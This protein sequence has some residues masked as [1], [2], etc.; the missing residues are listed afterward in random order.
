[1]FFSIKKRLREEDINELITSSTKSLVNI[2]NSINK[3]PKESP[4]QKTNNKL[5][6]PINIISIG[7][8]LVSLLENQTTKQ[9][10]KSNTNIK[11]LL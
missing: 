4:I 3:K 2:I 5:K 8:K 11:N 6:P 10:E 1:M 7:S 9:K